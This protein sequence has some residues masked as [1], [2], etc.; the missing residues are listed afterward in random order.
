MHYLLVSDFMFFTFSDETAEILLE[1]GHA[2]ISQCHKLSELGLRISVH[3][4]LMLKI[5][6]KYPE[7]LFYFFS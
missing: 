3:L 5:F 4:E 2:V 1:I 6:I 7:V